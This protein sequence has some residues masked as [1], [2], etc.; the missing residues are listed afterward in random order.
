MSDMS[1]AGLAQL[2]QEI[3]LARANVRSDA[4]CTAGLDA[5]Y[6]W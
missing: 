1:G 4:G 6:V 3:K 5:G 2:V